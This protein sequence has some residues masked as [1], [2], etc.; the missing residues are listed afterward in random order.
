M[1]ATL[2]LYIGRQFLFWI[3][4]TFL[5][6]L[7][8]VVIF[9]AVELLRRAGNRPDATAAV[10]AQMLILRLPNAMEKLLVFAILFGGMA[11]FWKLTKT[12]ELVVARASGVSVWQFLAP[13]I[14]VAM[15]LGICKITILNPVSATMLSRY[16]VLDDQIFRGQT[17]M[18]EV[19]AEGL[20]LRQADGE[21]Q[22]VI[23][24]RRVAPGRIVLRDVTV[25]LFEAD[26][27]FVGR[28]DAARAELRDGYWELDEVLSTGPGRDP[29]RQAHRVL[30]TNLTINKVLDSFASPETL[31]FWALPGFISLLRDSG[32]SAHRH[33]LQFQRLLSTPLLLCSMV[34]IAA[35]FSMRLQRRGGTMTMV[36]AGVLTGFA[37]YFLS[38]V[39]FAL[40]L[41]ATI[42]VALAAWTPAGASAMAGVAMLLHLEDG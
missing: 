8:V 30:K 18:L 32:F 24:A 20:W 29:V 31:S 33:E 34:L 7:A 26:E 42:P 22:Q 36:G 14:A 41:S 12:Q 28:L 3:A 15:L 40:G 39:M 1:T 13:A 10:I 38:D 11:I 9:D 6:L 19:S 37:L 17:S 5:G 23:H 2:G 25:F 35:T 4:V 16:E 21:N 27:Q